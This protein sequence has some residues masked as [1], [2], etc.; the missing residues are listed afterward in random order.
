MGAG[1]NLMGM[2]EVL[3]N[4]TLQAIQFHFETL[5]ELGGPG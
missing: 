5:T 1:G 4:R 2:D 3:G